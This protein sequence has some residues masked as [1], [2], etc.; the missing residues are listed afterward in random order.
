L[1]KGLIAKIKHQCLI[2]ALQGPQTTWAIL[3]ILSDDLGHHCGDLVRGVQV[4]RCAWFTNGALRDGSDDLG[5]AVA[6]YPSRCWIS[7]I[8]Y[9]IIAAV[10][11]W[12][13][14]PGQDGDSHISTTTW[15]F[16]LIKVLAQSQHLPLP[17]NEGPEWGTQE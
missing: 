17:N 6:G 2:K 10:L 16:V 3:I 7:F 1:I 4:L 5:L 11:I 13:P 8:D 14:E 9:P 12:L 15:R